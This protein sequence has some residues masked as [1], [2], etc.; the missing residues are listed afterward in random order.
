MSVPYF[1]SI[2]GRPYRVEYT[3]LKKD[4]FGDCDSGKGLI[5]VNNKLTARVAQETLLHEVLHAILAESGLTQ[6]LTHVDGLEE[7]IVRG[8]ERG[9]IGTGLLR[10]VGPDNGVDR[11]DP[12]GD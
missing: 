6:L 2:M 11:R 12:Q 5:R 1:V 8:L 4:L 7:A 9:L 10:G 3:K